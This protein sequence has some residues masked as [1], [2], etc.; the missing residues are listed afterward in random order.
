[1]TCVYKDDAVVSLTL[2]QLNNEHP[3]SI[4]FLGLPVSPCPVLGICLDMQSPCNKILHYSR[5]Q[6]KRTLT[7]I[8]FW[9]FLPGAKVLLWT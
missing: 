9:N 3:Y 5:V 2:Y 6:N 4:L 8:D 7:F 1:M